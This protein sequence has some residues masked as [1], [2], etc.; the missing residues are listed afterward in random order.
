MICVI[1]Q[2][3]LPAISQ[4]EASLFDHPWDF[5]Q[6][7]N[8]FDSGNPIYAEV[9]ESSEIRGYLIVSKV[10]CNECEIFRIAVNPRFRKQGIGKSLLAYHF[11]RS[12]PEERLFLEVRAD[13][14]PALKLY[15]SCGFLETGRRKKYYPDGE[16]AVIMM[17]IL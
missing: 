5:L 11:S 6:V 1:G 15:N 7:S 8:H 10:V 4:L 16:T 17:K 2:E 3:Q 13:N 14:A 9:G 12:Q